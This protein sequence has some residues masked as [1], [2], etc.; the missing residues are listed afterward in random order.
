MGRRRTC[1]CGV[2]RKCKDRKRKAIQ[3]AAMTPEQ[4]RAWKARKDPIARYITDRRAR[5]SHASRNPSKVSARKQLARS[6]R[7]GKLSRG[8]CEVCGALHG[9][10]RKDGT[11]VRVEG[12]HDDYERPLEVRWLCGEHHRPPWVVDRG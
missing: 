12:H 9:S 8:P 5:R 4:R 6:L 10:S 3:Y 7:S 1:N 11:K 2:C